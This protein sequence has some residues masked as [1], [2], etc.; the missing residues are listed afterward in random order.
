[1]QILAG[2]SNQASAYL[3]AA[4]LWLGFAALAG[5][6]VMQAGSG[7]ALNLPAVIGLLTLFVAATVAAFS[8]RYMRADLQ[9]RRFYLGLGA[10]VSSVLGWLFTG[11]L[12]VFAAFWCVSG[13]LLAGLIGHHHDWPEA[14]LAA[15]RTRWTFIVGDGA[16]V[17]ALGLL[18]W[19]AG[20]WQLDVILASA[21]ALS[22]LVVNLAALLMVAAV[23]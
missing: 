4:T 12:L 17:A 1:M 7:A 5:L 13:Q 10:L 18:G 3:I 2:K 16:L 19:Q 8:L 22:P 11:H 15:R 23:K 6:L 14:N 9:S 21:A 20:S